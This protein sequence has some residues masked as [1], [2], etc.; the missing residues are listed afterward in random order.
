MRVIEAGHVYECDMF[1]VTGEQI[2]DKQ[3]LSF[4]NREPGT[5]HPG[6][7]TQDVLRALIERTIHCDNCLPWP[8]NAHIIY[9]LRMALVLHEARALER[10]VEKH[11]MQPERVATANDGNFFHDGDD[12]PRKMPEHG[13]FEEWKQGERFGL[14]LRQTWPVD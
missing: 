9:H 6:T 5:E 7:R 4:V 14:A 12:G 1:D 2:P 11:T 3:L 13:P 10:K 8:G